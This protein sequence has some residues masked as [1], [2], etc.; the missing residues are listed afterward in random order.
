MHHVTGEFRRKDGSTLDVSNMG[1]P[2]DPDI[3]FERHNLPADLPIDSPD[4]PPIRPLLRVCRHCRR[5]R[6][7]KERVHILRQ[8]HEW[9]VRGGSGI[10]IFR[11]RLLEIMRRRNDLEDIRLMKRFLHHSIREVQKRLERRLIEGTHPVN[12]TIATPDQ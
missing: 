1:G 6:K 8:R 3:V 10:C 2:H 7:V 12:Q 11:Q 9:H 4:H 5:V